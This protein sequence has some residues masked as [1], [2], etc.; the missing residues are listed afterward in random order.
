MLYRIEL[1]R[2]RGE[3]Y[4]IASPG[5]SK[6]SLMYRIVGSVSLVAYRD[7]HRIGLSDGDAHPYYGYICQYKKKKFS[8]MLRR[9]AGSVMLT[10]PMIA[11]LFGP[12]NVCRRR[13][14]TT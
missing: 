11:L 14:E 5:V 10:K 1:Y 2:N 12:T 7:A 8:F 3:S 9:T 4:R 6:V 13:S